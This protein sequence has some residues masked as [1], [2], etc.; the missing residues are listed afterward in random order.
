MQVWLQGTF[1]V[2]FNITKIIESLRYFIFYITSE[3]ANF[4]DRIFQL[5]LFQ[6]AVGTNITID[7]L[8]HIMNSNLLGDEL[9]RYAAVNDLIMKTYEQKCLDASYDDYVKSMKETSWDSPAAEG[10]GFWL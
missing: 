8:C 4:Q 10:G 3:I 7:L 9:N 6:G 1:L 5:F 2:L